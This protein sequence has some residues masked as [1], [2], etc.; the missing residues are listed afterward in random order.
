MIRQ[1]VSIAVVGAIVAATFTTGLASPANAVGSTYDPGFVPTSGDLVGVGSD[2]IEIALDFLSK[3]NGAVL[4]FNNTPANTFDVASWAADDPAVDNASDNISL[5]EGHAA[6]LRPNGS[7]AGKARLFGTS[8]NLDVNFA[9]SSST[10][11]TTE[12]SNGLQQF[13]FAVDSLKLAVAKTATNA[14]AT[15]STEQMVQIYDG[16]LINWSQLGGSPGVIKPLIPQT[17]SGTRSFFI[18]Q[19]KA[20]NGGTDVVLASTVTSTQEH[21][22][23]DIKDDPNAVAPF[24]TARAKALTGTIKLE[25]GFKAHRAVYDV[26]R[27]ADLADSAAGHIGDKINQVFSDTGFICSAAAKPLI[28]AAGFDQLARPVASGGIA[29]GVCGVATQAAVTSF[30]TTSQ[31]DTDTTLAADPINGND[32]KV[33]LTAA[34]DATSDPVGTIT[35]KEGTTVLGAPVNVATASG[36]TTAEKTLSGVS[37]GDHTYSAVF[38]PTDDLAFNGSTSAPVTTTVKKPALVTVGL[39]NPTGTYGTKRVIAVS[40]TVDGVAATDPSVTIT[41]AGSAP[42]TVPLTSGAAFLTTDGKSSVDVHSVTAT[43]P[44]SVAHYAA[45]GSSSFTVSKATTKTVFT[46]SHTTIS[47]TSHGKANV[48]VTIN[49]ASSTVHPAGKIVLKSGSTTV[50]SGTLSSTGKVRITLKLLKKGRYS[51]KATFTPSSGDTLNYFGS[52]SSFHTLKVT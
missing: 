5:R 14:P 21:S 38:T 36:T 8:N 37:E 4:G 41:V 28:E 11:S 39:L 10:L 33:H 44:S 50:G 30:V 19:L 52:A 40:A 47:H 1:R 46:F 43:L 51:I 29:G 17:G 16:T 22:D 2:T 34:V 26:V 32:H 35:F 3:G 15:I 31:V 24:S 23:T 6:V 13:P 12:I 9:R 25:G 18:A 42:E 7:G 48:T 27:G 45:T 49:G 20:A